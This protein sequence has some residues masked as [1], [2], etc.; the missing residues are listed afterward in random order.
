MKIKFLLIFFLGYNLLLGITI[1]EIKKSN[2]YIYG[3]GK[4]DT[5]KDADEIAIKDLLSQ[6]S[7]Q[8]ESSFKDVIIEKNGKVHE[9]SESKV[10]TYSRAKLY[11]A[12]RIVDETTYKPQC[13]VIR[14]IESHRL[15]DIFEERKSRIR[16]LINEAELAREREKIADAVRNYYWAFALLPTIP[17]YKSMTYYFGSE[18]NRNCYSGLRDEIESLLSDI[19]FEVIEVREKADKNYLEYLTQAVYQGNP[20]ENI[21]V[22]YDN[23]YDKTQPAKWSNG[24][25]VI[26]L[27]KEIANTSDQIDVYIDYTYKQHIFDK[28][29]LSAIEVMDYKKLANAHHSLLLKKALPKSKSCKISVKTD[30]NQAIAHKKVKLYQK[31]IEK[32]TNLIDKNK[33]GL[34]RKYFTAAGYSDFNRLIDYGRAEI[35]TAKLTIN[36]LPVNDVICVRSVPMQFDFRNGKESFSENVNFIFNED[37]KIE[38]LTFAL[39]ESAVESITNNKNFTTLEQAHVINFMEMYKTAYCLKDISFAKNVFTE[40]ALIFTGTVIKKDPDYDVEGMMQQL[41]EKKVEIIKLSKTDYLKRLKKQF[42]RKE[43]INIHFTENNLKKLANMDENIFGIQI[44]QYYYSSNYADKGYLFLMF[45]LNDP[46]NPRITVR[47]WQPEK[48]EDGSIV[49]LED[50]RF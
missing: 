34:A 15:K 24:K 44:K 43:F 20:M 32:L 31:T 16:T 3:T 33:Y 39:S 14:Y 35:L 30:N 2:K 5:K 36:F 25:G 23:G 47:S 18:N 50:F 7:V 8:V 11:E 17:K 4:A 38:K 22:Y 27:N 28:Q 48:F 29:V 49:G 13:Y 21:L 26:R 1:Q 46:D 37:K 19:D 45:N 41:G 12:K 42:K 9:F 40:D 10:N 6:I